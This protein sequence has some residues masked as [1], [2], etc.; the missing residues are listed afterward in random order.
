M[1]IPPFSVTISLSVRQHSSPK[2]IIFKQGG[3]LQKHLFMF[4]FRIIHRDVC[5]FLH[6]IF[7]NIDSWA[8]TSVASILHKTNKWSNNGRQG[9]TLHKTNFPNADSKTHSGI[10]CILYT[11]TRKPD[12]LLVKSQMSYV[13]SVMIERCYLFKCKSKESYFLV[14]DCI[15]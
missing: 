2:F 5:S 12:I 7:T 3:D 10:F 15:E 8:L 4:Y 1:N 9:S 11:F 14:C 13:S 6:Q